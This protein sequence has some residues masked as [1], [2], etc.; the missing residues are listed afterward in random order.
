VQRARS[1]EACTCH[2]LSSSHSPCLC[3]RVY[4][5]GCMG[6]YVCVCGVI[7]MGACVCV[8]FGLVENAKQKHKNEQAR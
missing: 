4:V 2:A 8:R 1:D 6:V 7:C 3:V 5:C